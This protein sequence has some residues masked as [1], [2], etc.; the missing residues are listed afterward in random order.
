MPKI[1]AFDLIRERHQSAARLFAAGH[2]ASEV[3]RLMGASEAQLTRQIADPAFRDLVSRFRNT[4]LTPNA[5]ARFR[6]FAIAA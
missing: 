6:Q 2:S 4:E 5:N 3:A 1:N